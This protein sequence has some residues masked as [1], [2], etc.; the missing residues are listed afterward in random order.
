ME[1]LIIPRNPTLAIGVLL[2]DIEMY[3]LSYT[4]TMYHQDLQIKVTF[5]AKTHFVPSIA[6]AC[7][8]FCVGFFVSNLTLFSFDHICLGSGQTV[9]VLVNSRKLLV[10]VQC[11]SCCQNKFT[12]FYVVLDANVSAGSSF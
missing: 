3:L 10:S 11:P 6:W 9:S 12:N 8:N 5:S 1:T 4:G 7:K 2:V